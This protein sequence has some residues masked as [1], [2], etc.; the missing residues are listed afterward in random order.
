MEATLCGCQVITSPQGAIKDILKNQALY[1]DP[2]DQDFINRVT[3]NVL[4]NPKRDFP[5]P[6]IPTNNDCKAS[7]FELYKEL[8]KKLYY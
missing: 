4:Q 6:Q 3:L 2:F 7:Y 8:I 5:I 1:I